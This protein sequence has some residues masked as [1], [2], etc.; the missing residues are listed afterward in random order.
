M[1]HVA[2]VIRVYKNFRNYS[3]SGNDTTQTN[4]QTDRQTHTHTDRQTHRQADKH[5]D[6]QTDK[7]TQISTSTWKI[8]LHINTQRRIQIHR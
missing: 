3:F 5:T 7:H 6:K 1:A 8:H 2:D 4:T